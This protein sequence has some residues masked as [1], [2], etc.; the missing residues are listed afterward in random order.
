MQQFKGKKI[1]LCRLFTLSFY[2]EV[3]EEVLGEFD[4]RNYFKQFKK[5][6][7]I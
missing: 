2:E 6:K 4:L 5:K 3:W 1:I 7:K